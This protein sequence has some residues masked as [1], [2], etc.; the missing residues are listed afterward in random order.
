MP[1]LQFSYSVELEDSDEIH[2]TEY[3]FSRRKRPL[4]TQAATSPRLASD[5]S[6]QTSDARRLKRMLLS[7]ELVLIM[8]PDRGSPSIIYT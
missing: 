7:D 1:E 5:V 8:L 4:F 6:C 3:H 2:N